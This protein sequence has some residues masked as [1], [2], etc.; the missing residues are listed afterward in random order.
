MPVPDTLVGTKLHYCHTLSAGG[1]EDCSSACL[2]TIG[3]S[4]LDAGS[5]VLDL[6][7]PITNSI[8]LKDLQPNLLGLCCRHGTL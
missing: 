8:T 5:S 4:D 7:F 2:G 1:S 6:E 3:S